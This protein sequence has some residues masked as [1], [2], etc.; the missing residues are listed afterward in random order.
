MNWVSTRETTTQTVEGAT[1][2][3]KEGNIIAGETTWAKLSEFEINGKILN[4]DGKNTV[5]VRAWN[6]E[7]Y[8]AGGWYDGPI[9]L[10]GA[11]KEEKPEKAPEKEEEK[12]C[13]Y[14]ETF[15]TSAAKK[16]KYLIYLP[17]DYY[18]TER[19]YPTMYLLHQFNSD[20]TSYQ[21]D[22]I[23][24]VLDEGIENGM[25]DEMIVVIPNSEE[26][27]WWTGRWR[28]M[29]TE[30]LIPHI[31]SKYRTI[32][33]ARYRMTA[34]CSMGGQGAFSVAVTNPDYFTGVASFYGALSM[35]PTRREDAL[36]IAKQEPKEYLDYF[37]YSFICGNQDSYGFGIPAIELNQIFEERE[38]EHY[39]LIENGGHDST[40]YIPRFNECIGYVRS[41]MYQA[42]KG[43][44][45]LISAKTEI[46]GGKLK[47]SF[48]AS[49]GIEEYF[50][51]IPES[52]YT[53]EKEAKLSIPLIIQI[54]KNGDVLDTTTVKKNVVTAEKM[55]TEYE[56]DF[57]EDFGNLEDFDVVVKAAVFDKIIELK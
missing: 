39:F 30:D 7:P 45:K 48:E 56:F 54:V 11:Q 38:V 15:K 28:T 36:Y 1:Q 2:G 27:S 25:F 51:Q 40:F 35:A 31:D 13:F 5:I 9:S 26:E 37:S 8:G 47:V 14:E 41:N 53:K 46:D 55:S 19:Y 23:D 12:E 21:I 34:G 20:H 16:G 57:T 4:K 42:D 43:I 52:S 49:E 32:R 24:E 44:E 18:E 50:N 10:T 22:K 6:D 33:D 3:L 17:K 29:I